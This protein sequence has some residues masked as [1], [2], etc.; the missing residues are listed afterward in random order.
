MDN[1]HKDI[2]IS[3]TEDQLMLDEQ[4]VSINLDID[5]VGDKSSKCTVY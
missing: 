2:K 4:Q 1:F 5:S 3:E